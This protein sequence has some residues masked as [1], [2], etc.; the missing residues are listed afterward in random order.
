MDK[1]MRNTGKMFIT[2]NEVKCCT[3]RLLVSN[4]LKFFVPVC[5]MCDIILLLYYFTKGIQNEYKRTAEN[6]TV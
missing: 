1:A 6:R 2:V 4:I 3:R 5:L